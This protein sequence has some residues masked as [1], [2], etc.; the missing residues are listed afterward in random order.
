LVEETG[1]IRE[2]HRPVTS[3]SLT[4]FITKY[5][6][7]YTS[8]WMGFKFTKLVVIGT[9]YIGSYKSNYHTIRIMSTPAIYSN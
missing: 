7:E 8:P 5:C 1:V 2:N 4:N 6:I 3:K 9:D